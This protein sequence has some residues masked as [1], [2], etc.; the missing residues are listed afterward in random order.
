MF[1]IS[2]NLLNTVLNVKHGIVEQVQNEWTHI[3]ISCLPCDRSADWELKL[4]AAA[5]HHERVSYH[6]WPARGNIKI[7]KLVVVCFSFAQVYLCEFRL[8]EVYL[9]LARVMILTGKQQYKVRDG[10]ESG[11][12][13]SVSDHKD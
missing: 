13:M 7:E 9:D 3:R 11:G 2:C 8:T 5:Q 12:Y 4:S 1:D 10:Q 6:I